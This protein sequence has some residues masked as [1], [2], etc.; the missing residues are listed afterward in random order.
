MGFMIIGHLGTPLYELL[1][2]AGTRREDLARNSQFLLHAAL[3]SVDLAAALP[4]TTSTYLKV[5]DRHNEQLVSAYIT[6]GGARFLIL[7]DARNEV[8]WSCARAL[9][10]GEAPP[11]TLSPPTCHSPAPRRRAFAPFAMRCTS[12]T[13]RFCSTPFM[14]L[15]AE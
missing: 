14:R 4:S 3:D 12:C 10:H 5:V 8:R 7:H 9:P 15:A 13:L 11:T 1:D 6:P 2:F